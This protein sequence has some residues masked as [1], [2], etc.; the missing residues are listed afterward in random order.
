MNDELRRSI[1]N[2]INRELNKLEDKLREEFNSKL[3]NIYK[4]IIECNRAI[5]TLTEKL[6]DLAIKEGK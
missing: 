6:I 2:Q 5:N 3:D 4:N 1:T